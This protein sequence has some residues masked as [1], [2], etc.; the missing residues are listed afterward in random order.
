MS[1]IN[2]L[3]FPSKNFI[4]EWGEWKESCICTASCMGIENENITVVTQ[5]INLLDANTCCFG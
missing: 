2:L 4:D 1:L 5:Q 3:T